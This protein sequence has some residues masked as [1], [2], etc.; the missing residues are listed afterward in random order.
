MAGQAEPSGGAA[1]AAGAV[2]VAAGV[3][4]LGGD[5]ALDQELPWVPRG[6]G[7]V[8][9]CCC[10]L[11]LEGRQGLLIDAGLPVHRERVVRGLKALLPPGGHL[12]VMVTRHE[13]ECFGNLGAV[14][15]ELPVE[16]IYGF[17]QNPAD[18]F[19]ADTL[20]TPM[21]AERMFVLKKLG[22]EM[23]FADR[24]PIAL[25]PAAIGSL[26]T[27]WPHDAYS[28]VLFPSDLFGW[29]HRRRAGDPWATEAVPAEVD[30]DWVADHLVCKF[31]WLY[32]ARL[33]A[34]RAAL[35]RVFDQRDV[36]ALAPTHG[37]IVRGRE[38]AASQRRVLDAALEVILARAAAAEKAS[39]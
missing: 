37:T 26:R 25:L 21:P 8:D 24:R 10:Y 29:V 9:A 32:R 5:V 13:P 38:Q 11:I 1:A 22:D 33:G 17:G 15:N 18:F 7:G 30:A 14:L 16:R 28:G 27:V 3:F 6:V 35:A 23:L 2:E 36:T 39:A 4:A 20:R 34:I 31:E 19:H 12:E